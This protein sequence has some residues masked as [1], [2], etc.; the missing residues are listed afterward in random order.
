MQSKIKFFFK[1]TEDKK[2]NKKHNIWPIK[3]WNILADQE[4][5]LQWQLQ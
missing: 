1:Y 2:E 4:A 5:K 3:W